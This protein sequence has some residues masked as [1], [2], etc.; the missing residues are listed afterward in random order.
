MPGQ[1]AAGCDNGDD[2]AALVAVAHQDDCLPGYYY[3][4][5]LHFHFPRSHHRPVAAAV[6]GS[7]TCLFDI[8]AVVDDEEAARVASSSVA[9]DD[10]PVKNEA[11]ACKPRYAQG[12]SRAHRLRS[13]TRTMIRPR[14]L[15]PQSSHCP[16][17]WCCFQSSPRRRFQSQR[18]YRQ[19]RRRVLPSRC[20]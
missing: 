5:L 6:A 19:G 16:G 20:C 9:G 17:G 15:R 3:Y 14:P 12:Q 2:T 1:D 11:A 13:G 18:K 8:V 7:V 10:P 4:F